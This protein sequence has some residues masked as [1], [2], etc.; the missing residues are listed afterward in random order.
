[1]KKDVYKR[2]GDKWNFVSPDDVRNVLE[3]GGE[4]VDRITFRLDKASHDFRPKWQ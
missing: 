1:M 3:N 4:E 2:Q